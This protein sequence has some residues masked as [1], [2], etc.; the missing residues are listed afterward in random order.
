MSNTLK[1]TLK[2]LDNS[3]L[4]KITKSNIKIPLIENLN[5]EL[6][7]P[8][9]HLFVN[10]RR[11][12]GRFV[13]HTQISINPQ[14]IIT[15]PISYHE[16]P[17]LGLLKLNEWVD[18]R[19]ILLVKPKQYNSKKKDFIVNMGKASSYYTVEV[20]PATKIG[21]F[22]FKDEKHTIFK[23]N[24]EKIPMSR[25]P[26]ADIVEVPPFLFNFYKNNGFESITIEENS[27]GDIILEKFGHGPIQIYGTTDSRPL[28]KF[29]NQEKCTLNI[30]QKK[31]NKTYIPQ[32]SMNEV[33]PNMFDEVTVLYLLQKNIDI[34]ELLYKFTFN[35]SLSSK[36]FSRK[37]CDFDLILDKASPLSNYIT[38]LSKT[39]DFAP[40][41]VQYETESMPFEYLSLLDLPEIQPFINFLKDE[42][43]NE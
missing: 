19:R 14:L 18:N 41:L 28:K 4:L 8:D 34:N 21:Y 31:K 36:Y 12:Y 43:H 24:Q 27:D 11:N 22:N 37:K 29:L 23:N 3:N 32:F 9:P 17:V 6:Y 26:L 39:K 38:I 2:S 10:N 7:K 42:K 5:V 13:N 1:S 25:F 30:C 40:E 15:S 35:R 20:N 16:R 33:S